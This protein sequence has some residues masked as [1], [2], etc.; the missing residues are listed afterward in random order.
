M[1]LSPNE[2]I[3]IFDYT[4]LSSSSKTIILEMLSEVYELNP[5]ENIEVYI[6]NETG[7]LPM[8][9]EH[10]DEEIIIYPNTSF[11]VWRVFKNGSEISLGYPP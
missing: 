4:N 10:T 11:P 2:W 7:N 6:S 5:Q 3:H 1:K 9:I 8:T